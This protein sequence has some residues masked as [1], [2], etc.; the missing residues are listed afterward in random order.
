MRHTASI[1]GNKSELETVQ[2]V[3]AGVCDANK[4]LIKDH[5]TGLSNVAPLRLDAVLTRSE[6]GFAGKA[7][8][9][10]R[11]ED[12]RTCDLKITERRSS[13]FFAALRSASIKNGKYVPTN[14]WTD[15][16][17]Y[18]AIELDTEA[19][20]LCFETESQ[21]KKHI[22]WSLKYNNVVFV[23]DSPA[24]MVALT[25]LHAA[26]PYKELD[27]LIKQADQFSR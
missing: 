14:Q 19:G 26:L 2:Q 10:I 17:P 24:P 15:D 25:K 22:P 6:T 3:V 11:S 16:Y 1:Q 21:G 4:I 5:W 8:Y 9:S 13:N 20:I 27:R 12:I 7:T 23:V 18:L